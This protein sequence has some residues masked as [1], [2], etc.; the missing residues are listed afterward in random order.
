MKLCVHTAVDP[1]VEARLITATQSFFGL[2][3]PSLSSLFNR[4]LQY[5]LPR[6]PAKPKWVESYVNAPFFKTNFQQVHTSSKA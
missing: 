4:L 1:R 3:A 5:S 2:R 6:S